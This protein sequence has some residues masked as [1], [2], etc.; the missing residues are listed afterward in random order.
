MS[1]PNSDKLLHFLSYFMLSY[2]FFHVYCRRK[3]QVLVGFILLGSLL[4][5]LQSFT[6]YR[7]MEWL[8]LIMNTL[9]VVGAYLIHCTWGFRIKYLLID[10]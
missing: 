8:D 6:G 9:G 7:S 1:V 2:W 5:F 3:Y 10:G 4:E